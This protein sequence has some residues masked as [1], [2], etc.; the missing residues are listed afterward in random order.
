MIEQLKECYPTTMLCEAFNVHRSSYK[1]WVKRSKTISPKKLNEMK[2]V[3]TIFH[4]SKG[5]AGART[6]ADIATNRGL[7]LSRYRA[8]N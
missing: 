3:K 5:L 7:A 2:V 1:Y 4:E 6:I 8:G